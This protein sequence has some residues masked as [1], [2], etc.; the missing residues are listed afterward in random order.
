MSDSFALCVEDGG[1]ED[2]EVRKVYQRLPDREAG[3]EGYVRV[4][5]ESGEDYIYPSG[6]SSLIPDF[7]PP[8]TFLHDQSNGRSVRLQPDLQATESPRRALPDSRACSAAS[9]RGPGVRRA[10]RATEDVDA[11]LHLARLASGAP[12]TKHSTA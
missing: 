1:M 6:L 10:E 3:R 11:R 4:I 7:P 8:P 12:S 2:L 9:S 5:D